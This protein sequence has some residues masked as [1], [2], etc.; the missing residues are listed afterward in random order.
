MKIHLKK[1]DILVI[2]V[3]ILLINQMIIFSNFKTRYIKS[4]IDK[5]NPIKQEDCKLCGL[6]NYFQGLDFLV[7]VVLNNNNFYQYNVGLK[8]YCNSKMGGI[9]ECRYLFIKNEYLTEEERN[10]KNAP[11]L[12]HN[13]YRIHPWKEEKI[14]FSDGEDKS[15][16]YGTINSYHKNQIIYGTITSSRFFCETQNVTLKQNFCADC[17]EKVIPVTKDINSFLYD[18]KTGKVYSLVDK[19]SFCMRSYMVDI[20]HRNQKEIVFII[21][22]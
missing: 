10:H 16:T 8:H 12:I 22:N 17:T 15:G 3:T 2:I 13:T 20:L 4:D 14:I 6:S 1:K 9:D 21:R 7:M 11:Y 19:K 18:Y 5:E